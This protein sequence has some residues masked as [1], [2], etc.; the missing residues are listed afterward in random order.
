MAAGYPR[1]TTGI[2]VIPWM[3]TAVDDC[4]SPPL[5]TLQPGARW[6][7]RGQAQRVDG[8]A[9]ILPLPPTDM[10]ALHRRQAARSALRLIIGRVG[11]DPLPPEDSAPLPR[12]GLTVTD[13]RTAWC[14]DLIAS[15]T[16]L[17]C[18]GLPPPAGRDLW[19]A[20]IRPPRS[21]AV[22]LPRGLAET[23]PVITPD[24]ARPAGTLG[25][26]DV[27]LTGPET[28]TGPG[29][30]I[31]ARHDWRLTG[32]RLAVAPDLMPV[33]LPDGTVLAGGQPVA[34]PDPAGLFGAGTVLIRA[35][36]LAVL[37]RAGRLP[38]GRALTLV[39]FDL[40]QPALIRAGRFAVLSGPDRTDLPAPA[41][42]L[43]RGEAAILLGAPPARQPR[44]A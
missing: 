3:A 27:V 2:Y 13:G 31:T 7:W 28:E 17:V 6:S 15:G 12:P 1:P 42:L 44:A 4:P 32:A 40:P 30:P 29:L 11:T 37:G 36:D 16:L 43:S 14:L 23:C 39:T 18:H 19:L 33:V 10:Q 24:G 38:P 41:R 35:A 25:P 5:P 9:G 8:P 26:G 20:E 22:A 34:W 21:M